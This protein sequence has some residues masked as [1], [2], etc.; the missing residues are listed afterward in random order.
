MEEEIPR[1][2]SKA[3][4]GLAGGHMGPDAIARKVLLG[5]LWRPTLF[6]DAREWVLSCDTCQRAGRPLKRDFMPLFR[7]KPQEL[8]ERRGLDFVG[9]LPISK[10]H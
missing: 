2:L 9:P 7:S 4:E 6:A 10:I 8:F 5:G 3:H 1:V